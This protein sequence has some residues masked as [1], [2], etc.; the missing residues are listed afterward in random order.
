MDTAIWGPIF[1]PIFETICYTNTQIQNQR[2]RE[3]FAICFASNLRLVPCMYCRGSIFC[4]EAQMNN[5]IDPMNLAES[6]EF[7]KN[8]FAENTKSFQTIYQ[9]HEKVNDKL[10]KQQNTKNA[11]Y[12]SFEKFCKRFKFHTR[13]CT[14]K[15][16]VDQLGLLC[17]YIKHNINYNVQNNTKRDDNSKSNIDCIYLECA[18]NVNQYFDCFQQYIFV[19]P[20][21]INE[22]FD[23]NHFYNTILQARNQ[24]IV[25]LNDELYNE[26]FEHI[27]TWFMND[28]Y[29]PL[30]ELFP[31]EFQE[32]IYFNSV[33]DK[34]EF[35]LVNCTN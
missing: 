4:F 19:L 2:L 11:R 5:Q 17:V 30:L 24:F 14:M 9:L 26:N 35:I 6:I 20:L 10:D 33:L 8:I 23:N 1:W 21:I 18:K 12:I 7:W 31:N 29:N 32:N 25:D 28:V 22:I 15:D 13:T 16:F 3:Y 27:T 34:Y